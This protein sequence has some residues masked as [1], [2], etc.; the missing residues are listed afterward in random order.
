M[1]T[2]EDSLSRYCHTYPIPNKEARTIAKVL[3]DQHFNVY[4]LPDQLLHSDNGREFVNNLLKELFSEFKIQH[5]TTPLYNPSSNPV[6]RFHW[7]IIAML[8]TRGEGIQ[9]NW[10]LW[11]NAS[12]FAY[13]TTVSTSTGV[14][15][16]Y[17]MFGREA[18]QP[19]D[20]VFP[21]TSSE[22]RTM[23]QWNRDMLEERQHAYRSMGAVQGGRVRQN[24][25]LYKPLTQKIR[26]GCLVWYFDSRIV[27]GTSHK[28]RS[29]WAGPYRVS[30]L[31]ASSLA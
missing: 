16:H 2:A 27:P 20:W 3:G 23:H 5:T 10:N 26:V 29:L 15:P 9:D 6:E 13:N 21:T 19:V 31:I 30:R 22:K 1:L 8:R 25:Q 4:G 12:V 17:A 24:A 18:M 14:T 7:T 28:L 11:I